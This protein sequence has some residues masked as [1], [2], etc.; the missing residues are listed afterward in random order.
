MP[1]G[2]SGIVWDLVL[3]IVS[4]QG[5]RIANR[6]DLQPKLVKFLEILN[7]KCFV[8]HTENRLDFVRFYRGLVYFSMYLKMGVGNLH[9]L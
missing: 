3:N 9:R 4:M 2:V 8:K 6:Q 7:K 1:K 5:K